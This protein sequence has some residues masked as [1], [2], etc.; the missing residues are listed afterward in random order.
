M[1]LLRFR[2]VRAETQRAMRISDLIED[3]VETHLL[4]TVL[5]RQQDAPDSEQ[6]FLEEVATQGE[7]ILA[8]TKQLKSILESIEE[9]A[10][11]VEERGVVV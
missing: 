9:R 5:D 10:G 7:A 8:Y 6:G 3:E 4:D 1:S 11:E 2:T